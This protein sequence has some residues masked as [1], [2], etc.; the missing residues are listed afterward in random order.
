MTRTRGWFEARRLEL[1]K[2]ELGIGVLLTSA[3]VLVA[4]AAGVGLGRLGLYRD[5]PLTV[6]TAWL[7]VAGGIAAGVVW[8]RRRAGRVDA[9]T[10]A[11]EVERQGG[12]RRGSIAATLM[13]SLQRSN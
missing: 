10:L 11:T 13:G 5:H 7:V 8:S 12:L 3:I 6:L 2:R 1:R 4:L 9:G